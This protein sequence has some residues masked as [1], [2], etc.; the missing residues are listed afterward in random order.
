MTDSF[1]QKKAKYDKAIRHQALTSSY[2]F[3]RQEKSKFA[4]H[5]L[6][7]LENPRTVRPD[8]LSSGLQILCE[9]CS[10]GGWN[11]NKIPKT[12]ESEKVKYIMRK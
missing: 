11:K 3:S 8:F 4:V 10:Y 2:Y 5:E 12:V 9:K 1:Q 6:M 7:V